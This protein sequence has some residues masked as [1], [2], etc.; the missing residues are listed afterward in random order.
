MNWRQITVVTLLLSN[1][2]NVGLVS[3]VLVQAQNASQED[4]VVIEEIIG[5]EGGNLGKKLYKDTSDRLL[6]SGYATAVIREG[7]LK[8]EALVKF[9]ILPENTTAYP[10]AVFL[11]SL[12][13]TDKLD[14]IGPLVMLELHSAS[15]SLNSADDQLLFGIVSSFYEGALDRVQKRDIRLEVRIDLKN[16]DIAFHTLRFGYVGEAP[17]WSEFLKASYGDDLPEIVKISVQAVDISRA[18]PNPDDYLGP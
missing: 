13:P 11:Q 16:G 3:D 2:I 8:S 14:Y 10:D 15:L 1:P 6:S 9:T 4:N 7:A 17:I 5:S 12:Y 18:I